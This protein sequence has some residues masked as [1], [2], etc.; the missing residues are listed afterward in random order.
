LLFKCLKHI[1]ISLYI[2]KLHLRRA[3]RTAEIQ[4]G[5]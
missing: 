3:H 5:G 4:N 2:D 1:D